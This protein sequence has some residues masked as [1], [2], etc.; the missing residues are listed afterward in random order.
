MWLIR[1]A[2]GDLADALTRDLLSDRLAF[3]DLGWRGLWSYV[4]AAPP[5]TAIYHF[6]NEGW[7]VA[8]HIAA[9]Q[10]Y[11]LRKLGWRYTAIHFERGKDQPFPE[12]IW[13]PGFEAP[14]PYDGPTW[15]TATFEELVSPE[16]LE[17]LKGGDL[18]GRVGDSVDHH[19]RVDGEHGTRYPAFPELCGRFCRP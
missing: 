17:L 11:E 9:E 12:P 14:A 1:T 18:T 3:D 2:T 19:R 13:R 5:G 6:R 8:D 7:T 15:E 10:L 4:T 16:V